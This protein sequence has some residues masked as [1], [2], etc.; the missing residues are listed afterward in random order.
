MISNRKRQRMLIGATLILLPLNLLLFLTQTFPFDIVAEVHH[1][2]GLR[3]SGLVLATIVALLL[4]QLLAVDLVVRLIA[5]A[6][7]ARPSSQPAS[8]PAGGA[9]RQAPGHLWL[10]HH[11]LHAKVLKL[12]RD[13][14]VG[15]ETVRARAPRLDR[16]YYVGIPGGFAG[17]FE[18]SRGSI[19]FLDERRIALD[20][21]VRCR[22]TPGRRRSVF[23]LWRNDRLELE[24]SY[25]PPDDIDV[26]DAFSSR[27]DRDFFVWLAD[28]HAAG[29][30]RSAATRNPAP[31]T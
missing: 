29:L 15:E 8:E 30:P 31:E 18:S 19:F 21:S 22:V 16:G 3:Y 1:A 20:D 14:G 5:T 26:G 6:R 28:S 7:R 9:L 4:L 25:A 11:D 13:A 23:Q 2:I 12:P 27:Y 24:L 10:A 17:M